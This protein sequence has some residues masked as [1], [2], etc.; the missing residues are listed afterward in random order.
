MIR[1]EVLRKDIVP[2]KDPVPIKISGAIADRCRIR[3]I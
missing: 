3:H 1:D 2:F